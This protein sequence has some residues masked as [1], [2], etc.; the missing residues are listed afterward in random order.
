MLASDAGMDTR[1]I[2]TGAGMITGLEIWR[3]KGKF[4]LIDQSPDKRFATDVGVWSASASAAGLNAKSP[5]KRKDAK[6][7]DAASPC[8]PNTNS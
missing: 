5:K 7:Q 6:K 1:L 2:S 4:I 8:S 3:Q